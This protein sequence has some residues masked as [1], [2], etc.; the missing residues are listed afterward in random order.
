MINTTREF[1]LAQSYGD[2]NG[3]GRNVPEQYGGQQERRGYE[4]REPDRHEFPVRANIYERQEERGA[5]PYHE[6][7][8]G[9]RLPFEY[10]DRHFVVDDWR[11]RNLGAPP[12]G[13]H[14]VQ[15]GGDY[16]LAAI[17]TGII[18]QLLLNH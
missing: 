8:M 10:R 9:D 11:G 3:R 12:G 17:A 16:V 14:W 4:G 6:F 18:L 13:Y 2:R 5:G 1:S 15:T 7:H